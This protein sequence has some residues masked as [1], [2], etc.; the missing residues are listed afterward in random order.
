MFLGSALGRL[1]Q[2]ASAMEKRAA[3]VQPTVIPR[4]R[5]QTVTSNVATNPSTALPVKTGVSST[6]P[7]AKTISVA[8]DMFLKFETLAA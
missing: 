3:L 1:G 8:R 6:A 7:S 2:L 4:G 5:V